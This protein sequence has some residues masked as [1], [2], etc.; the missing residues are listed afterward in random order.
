MDEMRQTSYPSAG[1]NA[2]ILRH[3][4]TMV[5]VYAYSKTNCDFKKNK[6][7]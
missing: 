6:N 4:L 5:Q 7:V 1:L 2:E 3:N